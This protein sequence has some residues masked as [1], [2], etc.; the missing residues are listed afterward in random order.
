MPKKALR[1]M[2]SEIS[3]IIEQNT[4]K[5]VDVKKLTRKRMKKI[6]I[7]SIFLKEKYLSNGQFDKLKAR[8]VAGGHMQD[9]SLYDDLSS[10]TVST[11]GAFI[12]AT[13]AAREAR[14]V[15]TVDIKG[16]YLN[17][18]MPDSNEPVL[19]RLDPLCTSI[20]VQLDPSYQQ[21]R[22]DDGSV[23]VELQKALY[24]LVEAA[25]L[26][27]QNLSETLIRAGFK[28]NHVDPCVFNRTN[29]KGTQCTICFHVDDLLITSSD[30]TMIDDVIKDL[31]KQYTTISVH[32][33][34]V[35]SYLGLTLDFTT[36]RKVRITAEG[37]VDDLLK[38][39]N[40][41]GTAKT[42]SLT[43]L[44]DIDYSSPLL[45]E[46]ERKK[47]HTTVAKCLYLS[48][49][50]RPDIMLTVSFLVTR[51]AS[52]TLQ[53]QAKLHRLLRY[54][55]GTRQLGLTLSASERLF[56]HCFIDASYGTHSD[57]KSHTGSSTTLGE[58]SIESV[59]SKQKLVSKS[60]AEA[61]LISLSDRFSSAIWVSNFLTS[62][63]Y[64]MGPAIVHQ[65]NMSTIA[66]AEKGRSTSAR[67][68][69]INLRYF[70]IQDRIAQGDIVIAYTPTEDMTADI[71]TKPLQGK[72]FQK[73][74]RDLL[75]E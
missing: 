17:S 47:F 50:T 73:L 1:A 75:G 3:Q 70:F 2:V 72:L 4:V 40:V 8:L 30:R 52:A 43:D 55:N 23:V 28:A 63:G 39:C 33:G 74:R 38:S 49:R 15:V 54:I 65:D 36:P 66:L 71:L 29:S 6:I 68:R 25:R 61:E 56:V 14:H 18:V 22:S 5:P 20:L 69:H 45:S 62:Q 53:D 37:F 51:V 19:M 44:F 59:S 31:E 35:H 7:S 48:K 64:P 9:R 13:L 60:S 16:A 58:G 11:V 21:Y 42:P 26:W 10:P 46:E 24:G 27:Y 67:T 32:E 34:K 12:T 41:S 57:Y